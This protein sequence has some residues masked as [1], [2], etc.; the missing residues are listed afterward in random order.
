MDGQC[1]DVYLSLM[2][3]LHGVLKCVLGCLKL[4][5]TCWSDKEHSQDAPQFLSNMEFCSIYWW[6]FH[7]YAI[8]FLIW[9]SKYLICVEFN[10]IEWTSVISCISVR[11]S[12]PSKSNCLLKVNAWIW[13]EH[14]N[15][16]KN[17]A[18]V[19]R[20]TCPIQNWGKSCYV[21][22]WRNEAENVEDRK[23]VV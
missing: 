7:S 6:F 14:V 9:N 10:W 12:F 23:S 18:K 5:R 19:L 21:D 4:N 22:W 3:V 13:I 8:V 11:C 16:D 20:I 1:V 15:L 2:H 17:I